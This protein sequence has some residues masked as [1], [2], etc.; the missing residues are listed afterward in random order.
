MSVKIEPSVPVVAGRDMSSTATMPRAST[1]DSA[2]YPLSLVPW[3][4]WLADGEMPIG[5]ELG[6][7]VNLALGAALEERDPTDQGALLG[8]FKLPHG[9]TFRERATRKVAARDGSHTQAHARV[10]GDQKSR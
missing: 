9:M 10:G 2:N 6:N 4:P 1:E 3:T 8:G 5:Q 7:V